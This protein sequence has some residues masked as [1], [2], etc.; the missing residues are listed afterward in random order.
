M[1]RIESRFAAIGERTP[2]CE[3]IY[4]NTWRI[5]GRFLGENPEKKQQIAKE[6][7]R[8]HADGKTPSAVD[9]SM[10]E[11]NVLTASRIVICILWLRNVCVQLNDGRKSGERVFDETKMRKTERT[12]RRGILLLFGNVLFYM[13]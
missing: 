7:H 6:F 1:V 5:I 13:H 4:S 2:S 3:C 11:W 8:T 12:L 10:R 9:A